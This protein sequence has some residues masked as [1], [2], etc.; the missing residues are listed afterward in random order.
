MIV[1]VGWPRVNRLEDVAAPEKIEVHSND[2]SRVR[3]RRL[4]IR[5][6]YVPVARNMGAVL[7]LGG[8]GAR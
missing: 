1:Q 6:G 3:E 8:T 7:E 4:T 2:R 5:R